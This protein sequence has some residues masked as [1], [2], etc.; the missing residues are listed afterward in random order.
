MN[1]MK[2]EMA[3]HSSILAWETPRREDSGAPQFMGFQK[4][5]M[6]EQLNDHHHR[7]YECMFVHTKSWSL[8]LL[9]AINAW[10]FVTEEQQSTHQ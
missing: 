8:P 5:D 1:L 9:N 3:A 6:T 2:E 4:L 7:E 10:N